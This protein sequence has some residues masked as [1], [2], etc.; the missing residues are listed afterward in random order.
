MN[1][2]VQSGADRPRYTT[3]PFPSYRYLPGLNPHPRRDPQGHSYGS[4][5][6]TAE[7]IAPENWQDSACYLYGVDLFNAGYWW[8]CHE[9]FEAIWHAVGRRTLQGRFVQGLIQVAAANLKAVLGKPSSAAKLAQSALDR[10]EHFSGQY[11]GL[12]V[13][14]FSEEL[15]HWREGGTPRLPQI[16]LRLTSERPDDRG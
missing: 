4:P 15:R 1:D 16:H 11:M 14:G 2:G 13:R 12:D 3:R 10:L 8:E 5:E 6:P 9:A 7:P